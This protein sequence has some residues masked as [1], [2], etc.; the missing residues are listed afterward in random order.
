[1]KSQFEIKDKTM[2]DDI[3]N[4][5]EFGTLALCKDNIPYSVPMNFT[6]HNDLFYF[7]G[8][9]KGKKM[10]YIDTNSYAS[11]SLVEDIS[12]IPSYFSSNDELSCPATHFFKS[13]IIDGTIKIVKN[14]QEKVD[15]LESLMQKLQLEGKYKD[16]NLDI[17][18]KM[19]HAT[20][21]FKLIP[22][23]I[24]GKIKLGQHLPKERFDLIIEHLEKRGTDN[25]KKT[26]QLMKEIRYN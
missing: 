16:M 25:D 15:A 17:Y 14:Y 19:I 26:L 18:Q 6:Y 21:V 3:I 11:F 4:T 1:M 8:S 5:C 7:H 2:I 22:K 12:F 10:Q 24:K 23:D 9:K 20:C 13:L